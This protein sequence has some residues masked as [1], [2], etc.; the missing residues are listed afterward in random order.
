MSNIS[1]LE[2][3]LILCLIISN[4]LNLIYIFYT[5][6]QIFKFNKS[7]KNLFKSLQGYEILK[8]EYDILIEKYKNLQ[9]KKENNKV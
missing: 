6:I 7:R 8:I 2:L 1:K 9:Q 4:I 5:Y 3:W